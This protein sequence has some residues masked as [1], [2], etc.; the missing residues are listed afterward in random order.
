MTNF[1]EQ[2]LDALGE[3]SN[4]GSGTAST[5]LADLLDRAVDITVP[6]VLAMPLADA[7]EAV[8]EPDLLR[9]AV[10][11]D[12]I[13]DMH[14]TV[15]L[16]FPSK[17]AVRLCEMLGVEVDTEIGESALGEIGNILGT[18]YVLALGQMI[19]M[20]VEPE[21]PIT[22]TDMLGAIVSSV[23][24]ERDDVGDVA[25]LLD[26]ALFVEGEQCELSFLLVPSAEAVT[27]VL[28]RIGM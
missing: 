6:K 24:L 25:L 19:G 18:S 28:G 12:I 9:K 15:L 11:L 5:A 8:G 1:S 16:L 3:L 14:A 7:V 27:E 2:Q 26:S 23:L 4:I 21:P 17:D 10:R 20:E 13:G 22:L